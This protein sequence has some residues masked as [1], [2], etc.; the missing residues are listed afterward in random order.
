MVKIRTFRCLWQAEN[1]PDPLADFSECELDEVKERRSG[2]SKKDE[3][4]EE[5]E[6]EEE[7][8]GGGRE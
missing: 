5:E 4:E 3:E 2:R 1:N 8:E 6:E 7:G